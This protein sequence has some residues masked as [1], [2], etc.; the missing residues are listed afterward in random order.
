MG[1]TS[2][3]FTVEE[4]VVASFEASMDFERAAEI[5]GL[6]EERAK[7]DKQFV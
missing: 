7:S 4:A 3:P 6:S 5:G 2:Q 1:T